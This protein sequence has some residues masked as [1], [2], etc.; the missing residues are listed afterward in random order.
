MGRN[1]GSLEIRGEI[2]DLLSVSVWGSWAAYCRKHPAGSAMEK[3]NEKCEYFL[4]LSK[5][6]KHVYVQ[7]S[8]RLN[9]CSDLCG[10]TKE[11]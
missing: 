2:A 11:Q 10:F 3:R 4:L 5:S 7:T 1:P 6:V 9:M 8:Q